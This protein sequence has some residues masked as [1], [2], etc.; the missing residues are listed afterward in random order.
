[1]TTSRLVTR[2]AAA[3][4][5]TLAVGSATACSTSSGDASADPD[6]K[7]TIGVVSGWSGDISIA[8]LSKIVLESQGYTVDVQEFSDTSLVYVATADGDI[9]AMPGWPENSQKAAYEKYADDLE[10][11][12]KPYG[13]GSLFIAVPDY[14]T[15]VQSIDDLVAHADEFDNAIVGIEAG[16]GLTKIM[17]DTVVPG[18]GLENFDLQLSSTAAMLAQLKEAIDADK[19]IAVTLWAP[20]WANSAFPIRPLEDPKGLFGAK[21]SMHILAHPGFSEEHPEVSDMWAHMDITDEQISELDD[22]ISNEY[23]AGEEQAAVQEWLGTNPGVA[24]SLEQYLTE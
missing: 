8:Y 10:D 4:A 7:L 3:A 20:F 16:S 23:G 1:M 15:D 18:Y 14:M 5:L 22:L 2:V 19:P 12:A 17:Q 9:D 6:K 11:V 24:E 21:E 13:N